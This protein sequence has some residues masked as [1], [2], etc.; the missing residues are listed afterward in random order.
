MN[1]LRQTILI[2]LLIVGC[3][4]FFDQGITYCILKSDYILNVEYDKETQTGGRV[5]DLPHRLLV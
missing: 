1:N 5:A 2:A 4:S 3:D